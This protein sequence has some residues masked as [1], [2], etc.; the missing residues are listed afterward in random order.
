[1]AMFTFGLNQY[2]VH[3]KLVARL[4]EMAEAQELK[5]IATHLLNESVETV[6]PHLRGN[7][8][9]LPKIRERYLKLLFSAIP[10]CELEAVLLTEL[11]AL[12]RDVPEMKVDFAIDDIEISGASI[13]SADSWLPEWLCDLVNDIIDWFVDLLS[14]DDRDNS[15]EDN[16]CWPEDD[17]W[18]PTEEEK[19][20][21]APRCWDCGSWAGNPDPYRTSE[22]EEEAAFYQECEC[23]EVPCDE[24]GPEPDP[25]PPHVS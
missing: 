5:E 13:D 16:A 12:I 23:R 2:T 11:S 24:P 17:D 8:S 9:A 15:S 20:S 14:N 4:K 22:S 18:P 19:Y 1:M 6:L 21:G 10:R 25:E 3:P 7:W